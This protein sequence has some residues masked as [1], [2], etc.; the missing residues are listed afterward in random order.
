[1][2]GIPFKHSSNA[3]RVPVATVALNGAKN[4]GILAAQII[5]VH[6]DGVQQAMQ[7]YKKSLKDKVAVMN[8]ELNQ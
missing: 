4:A 3:V 7:S 1:M 8:A 6:D 5:A 2:A